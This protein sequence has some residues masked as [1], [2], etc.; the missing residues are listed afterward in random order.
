MKYLRI[1]LPF[2]FLM[3]I[4]PKIYSQE[5]KNAV[6]LEVLGKS[7]LVFDVNYGRYLSEKFQLG[8][9]LG[10]SGVNKVTYID[11]TVTNFDFGVPI[12]GSYAF[13]TKKHHVVSE[14]GILLY[15]AANSKAGVKME[16]VAPFVSIGY[17][18]KGENYVFRLPLYFFYVG[19]NDFFPA[20]IPWVGVSVGSLF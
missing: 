8:V 5:K 13:S 1:V 20:V 2:A 9:G 6:S 12:F 16:E 18:V 4:S 14:F 11:E 17:E 19:E 3:L 15:G 7:L 10:L